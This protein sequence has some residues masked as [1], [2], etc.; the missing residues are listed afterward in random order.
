[1]SLS[2][3]LSLT[4]VPLQ[5]AG[6]GGGTPADPFADMFVMTV[7]TSNSGTSGTDQFTIPIDSSETYNYSTKMQLVSGGGITE[8]SGNTG[9][10]TLTGG[11]GAGQYKVG[12][13]G[14]FPKILF[15]NAADRLKLVGVE[16]FG[17]LV[18]S[19][20]QSSA[21]RGCNNLA[22]IVQ[23]GT[24]WNAVT[25][26]SSFLRGSALVSLPTD[27][28][29]G[30]GLVTNA[31]FALGTM[32]SLTSVNANLL[33]HLP[34]VENLG[35]F[36]R[37]CGLTTIADD[38][39]QYTPNVT[40]MGNIFQGNA[41]D[42]TAYSNLLIWLEAN[43]NTPSQ[44]FNG[45]NSNYNAAGATARTSLTDTYGWTINDSGPA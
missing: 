29:S 27:F 40:E 22:S 37:D 30:A 33:Q 36:L 25:N 26:I 4:G 2:L 34:L 24:P 7:Q 32:S 21:F 43:F 3:G 17:N 31:S 23:L 15:H 8:T 39:F 41:F 14:D 6:G 20:N 42:T 45:G 11:D 10:V 18:L 44:D 5:F 19:S 9:A 12:I 13:S 35:S 28:F 16:S 1:M 38:F